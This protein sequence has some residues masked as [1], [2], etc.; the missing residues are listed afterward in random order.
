MKI[1]EAY[2]NLSL[3]SG[4]KRYLLAEGRKIS[5]IDRLYRQFGTYLSRIKGIH[6]YQVLLECDTETE[7][8]E[9]LDHL[10]NSLWKDHFEYKEMPK[11]FLRYLHFLHSANALDPSLN[12]EGLEAPE[13]FRCIPESDFTE[14]A[15]P[16]IKDGK[17]TIIANPLLIKKLIPFRQ[18]WPLEADEAVNVAKDFYRSMLPEMTDED[19]KLKIEE[20]LQ[21][22]TRSKAKATARYVKIVFP[23]S[24]EKIMSGTDAM[25]FVI[26][27][28]GIRKA[29]SLNVMHMKENLVVRQIN[30]RYPANYKSLEDG[31][32]L[33]IK[34]RT[35]DKVKTLRLLTSLLRLPYTISLTNLTPE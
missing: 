17:L 2:Y 5:E 1:F 20:L 21:P 13:D 32:W 23:D 15:K 22:K 10:F 35:E 33:N 25:E 19:W 24:S 30:K 28:I 6:Y 31:L 29:M 16:Y 34:G 11:Y 26:T 8:K 9:K 14:Y 12:I 4:L 27:D 7:F 3:R 18:T